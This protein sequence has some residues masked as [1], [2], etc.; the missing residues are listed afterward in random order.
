SRDTAQQAH[1]NQLAAEKRRSR[2]ITWTIVGVIAVVV[3]IVVVVTLMNSSRSIP[4]A[5]PTPTSGTA[6]GGILFE[7]GA[8]AEGDAPDEVNAT[9]VGEPNPAAAGETPTEVRRADSADII[10]YA[11]ANCVHY[12]SSEDENS[13]ALEEQRADR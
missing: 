4:D 12:A 3:A 9:E 6:S 1:A 2:T 10:I 7:E 11:D 5:G 13:E 8:P